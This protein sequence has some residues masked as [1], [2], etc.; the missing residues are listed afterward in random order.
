MIFDFFSLIYSSISH[1]FHPFIHSFI[2][3]FIHLFIYSFIFFFLFDNHFF[4]ADVRENE[5][6]LVT[7]GPTFG[8]V[9]DWLRE[10]HELSGP[11][12]EREN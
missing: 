1:L 9:S 10:W 5:G 7:I 3:P 12:K 8:F 2:H 4:V 11:I 6:D